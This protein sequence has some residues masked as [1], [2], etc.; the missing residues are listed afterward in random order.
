MVQSKVVE[1]QS[2]WTS[3]ERMGDRF[4]RFQRS[5]TYTD[6]IDSGMIQKPLR[7]DPD[8]ICEVDDRRARSHAFNQVRIFQ[9]HAQIPHGACEP[10][11]AHRFLADEPM[12][13]SNCFVFD[14]R[15]DT[16]HA[17]ARND[18]V[19]SFEGVLGIGISFESRAESTSFA[20]RSRNSLHDL[21]AFRIGIPKRQL[22][23]PHI[24]AKACETVD[25]QW[26]SN[27]CGSNQ[28]D[29]HDGAI[30]SITITMSWRG[31]STRTAIRV[32]R[33]SIRVQRSFLINFFKLSRVGMAEDPPAQVVA[34][35]PQTLPARKQSSSAH[36]AR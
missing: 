5:I 25:Q 20:H 30:S 33:V 16:T 3:V 35:A 1:P 11:S 29:L 14:S 32:P 9:H 22:V 24:A 15:I 21:H 28:S 17:N 18:V 4:K 34:S 10:A 27:P 13:Q 8:W 6:E 31:F 19:R 12:R 2:K 23:Q 7:N 26:G 36:P